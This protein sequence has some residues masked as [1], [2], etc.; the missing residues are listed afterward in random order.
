MKN[1]VNSRFLR[2]AF[3]IAA[4]ASVGFSPM[5]WAQGAPVGG[6]SDIDYTGAVRTHVIP[7]DQLLSQGKYADA[8]DMY[9]QTL[10]NNPTD[11][12][13]TVGLGM[14]LAKQFKLDGADDMF[15]RVLLQDP[16]NAMA[17]AGKA[18]VALNR[19]QSSSGTIRGQKDSILKYAEDESRKAVSLAP[20]NAEAHYALGCVLREQGQNDAAASEFKTALSLDPKHSYAYSSLGRI[21]L[22][23]GSTAQ[24]AENLRRAVELNSGNSSAHFGLG[25][26]LFQ[27]GLTDEAIKEL[28]T[29]LYQFPNS[30]PVH[31]ALGD[32]YDKQ[33]NTAAAIKEY[34]VAITIKP[35]I[36]DPYLKLAAI[37]ESRGDLELA[38]ADLRSGLAQMPYNVDLR[39]RIADELLKL[40]KADDAI[41]SYKTI[42]TMRANDPQAIKGLT[43]A[44][45]IKAQKAAAGA[46]LASNDY[47]SAIHT[48]GDAI[49]LNPN[50]M[51]LR[52]AEAKLMAMAGAKPDMSQIPQPQNDGERMQYASALMA[53]GN[54]QQAT[55]M[56][57]DVV[58]RLSTDPK[59]A[60][61]VAD[62]ALMMDDLDNAE[63]AYKKAQAL[64]GVAARVDRGLGD[65]AKGRQRALEDVRVADELIKKKQFDGATERYRDA[66]AVNPRLADAHL[67]L[68]KTLEK[69]P[70]AN[71]SVLREAAQQYQYYVSLQTTMSDKDKQKMLENAD[72]LKTKADKLALKEPKQPVAVGSGSK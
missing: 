51:E 4:A 6:S 53:Q 47:D 42:L 68:A 62:L 57:S 58:S 34:Q 54:F 36:P 5:V 1:P 70:K 71:S 7:A 44:L 56:V 10:M 15:D 66:I 55:A 25:V 39:M 29:S 38:L 52:L 37:R 28:N 30:A 67:G 2:K 65:V 13:A 8:E 48:L 61:A 63:L 17:H 22:D 40:E 26:A 3:G 21:Q 69:L 64:G 59:Q 14:A 43:S 35:E 18:T 16:N 50:D 60:F 27:T 24:A 32:A 19:L 11:M 31:M 33:G 23:Q 49:K 9:R 12:G 20:A 45:C 46:L 72:K 41:K